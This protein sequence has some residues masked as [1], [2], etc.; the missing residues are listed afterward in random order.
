METFRDTEK[1]NIFS[2]IRGQ[3]TDPKQLGMISKDASNIKNYVSGISYT[4]NG[5]DKEIYLKKR[6]I[7]YFRLG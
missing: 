4:L 6:I 2:K 5:Y 1:Q 3:K 7:V